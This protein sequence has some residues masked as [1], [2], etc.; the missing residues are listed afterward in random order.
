MNL[1]SALIVQLSSK[2]LDLVQRIGRVLRKRKD[3][4][5]KIMILCTID[6]QDEKW[7]KKALE[8]FDKKK[9]EYVYRDN[10]IT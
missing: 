3:H 10:V 9:I 4:K 7:A 8:P 1:D 5:A 6:T 2:Q